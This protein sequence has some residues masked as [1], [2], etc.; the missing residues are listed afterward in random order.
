[1]HIHCIGI[2]H[3][4]TPIAL[5]EQLSFND[6]GVRSALSR[7]LCE[8]VVASM[9]EIVILSTCNRVELYA[10]SS[11]PIFG[12]LE[13]FLSEA[14]GVQGNCPGRR[15]ARVLARATPGFAWSSCL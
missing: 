12:E 1:M 9:A 15:G 4:T 7:L 14:R 5:R 2:N 13:A 11:R 6:N 3:T 10:V 8:H